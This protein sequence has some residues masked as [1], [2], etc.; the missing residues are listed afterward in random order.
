MWAM[1]R[2]LSIPKLI[3]MRRMAHIAAAAIFGSRRILRWMLSSR[4]ARWSAPKTV[5]RS[6][7][8]SA[9]RD[10][11]FR[12]SGG[13]MP[14]RLLLGPLVT[15]LKQRCERAVAPGL[16]VRLDRVN[17]PVMRAARRAPPRLLA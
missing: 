10:S 6:G 15:V 9:G 13:V 14:W 3:D 8:P 7:F 4:V 17:C 1:L 12:R 11:L 2:R 5:S 16:D